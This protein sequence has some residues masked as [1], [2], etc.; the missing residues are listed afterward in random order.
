MRLTGR[1]HR[2]GEPFVPRAPNIAAR[3]IVLGLGL[4]VIAVAY[5]RALGRNPYGFFCDEAL[6]G[7]RSQ[8]LIRNHHVPVGFPL[9]YSHFGTVA[10]ILPV[11]STAPFVWLL[12]LNEF[13]VRFSSVVLGLVTL[14]VVWMTMRRIGLRAPWIAVLAFALSPIVVHIDRLNFGHAPGLF[15]ISVGYFVWV[16]SVQRNRPGMAVVAGLLIGMSAYAY[17][18]FFVAT[19]L[20]LLVVV[21]SELIC[22]RFRLGAWQLGC[23]F[24][25]G[26]I[27]AY[28]PVVLEW[29]TNPVFATRF[30]QKD[31]ADYGL[32]SFDRLDMMIQNYPKYFGIRFL[33]L[34]GD[35]GWPTSSI[36]RHSVMGAGLLSIWVL[37]LLLL[38]VAGIACNRDRQRS[39]TLL[40]FLL[41]IPCIPAPDLITTQWSLSPYTYAMFTGILAVPFLTASGV[42]VLVDAHAWVLQ[43]A[44][45]R[46]GSV[47]AGDWRINRILGAI[48]SPATWG[49]IVVTAGCVFVF[50][51]Y[52][53]YPMV[54]SGYWGWQ[55]G[56][57][58]MARYYRNH[59]GEF[60]EFVMEGTFNQ[61]ATLLDFYVQDSSLRNTM[62]I[63]GIDQ[64]VSGKHQLFGV[65]EATYAT[66]DPSEWRIVHTV[67]YPN[68]D[69]AF[70]M[71]T[72]AGPP[73]G[74][75]EH[76]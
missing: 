56:P 52:A 14:G 21:F 45:R 26:G 6:I 51:A 62:K 75:R 24:V 3:H 48:S 42:D 72:R 13:A 60:D 70:R 10:G 39:R 19:P 55:A 41:L 17:P 73:S 16:G 32:F 15:L 34:Q 43:R 40:P 46:G 68:G 9:F 38:G 67:S 25:L 74:I 50:S 58:E 11:V 64:Y 63:G 37:P 66:L 57:R 4:I 1:T 35:W 53:H 18:G 71:V 76:P 20:F 12:G 65:T 23:P 29:F 31:R 36:Q 2:S 30:E 28:L 8:E 7:L 54:S 33:F 44:S 47:S 61:P 27:V 69:I 49:A 22:F 59:R 5:G